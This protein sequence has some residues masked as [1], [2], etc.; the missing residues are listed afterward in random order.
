MNLKI[1][2]FTILMMRLIG[3]LIMKWVIY[4]KATAEI[5]SYFKEN[6]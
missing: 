2:L 3:N 4:R 1:I 5:I 6:W